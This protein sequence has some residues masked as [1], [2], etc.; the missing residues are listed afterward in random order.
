[1]VL[2]RIRDER[3]KAVT[4]EQALPVGLRLGYKRQQKIPVFWQDP[5]NSEDFQRL[6]NIQHFGDRWRL[7]QAPTAKRAGQTRSLSMDRPVTTFGPKAQNLSLSLDGGMVESDVE[8]APPE[9]IPNST[10]LIRREHDE[11]NGP[12]AHSSE[13]GDA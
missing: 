12:G 8:T 7:F 4:Q 11:R 13:L 1:L 6:S 2:Q 9:W 5:V 3:R 10:F